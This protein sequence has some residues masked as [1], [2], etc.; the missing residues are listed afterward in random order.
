MRVL[1][2]LS[3][4]VDSAV[5]AYLLQ[6]Q[7]FDVTGAFMK[8]YISENGN[9]STYQ[10]AEEAIK[11]AEFL[12]I[13]LLVFDMQSEYQDRIINYIYDGYSKWITPNPDILCNSL[14]KFDVFLNKAIEQWFDKIAMGHYARIAVDESLK[15]K[16][17][18]L[19]WVDYHKDQSY[20]LAWLNQYQLSKAIFPLWD[21]PKSRVREIAKEIWLPNADRPDS[22]WLCF[23][24]NI[25]IKKFLEQKLPHQKW[26]IVLSDWRV[27]GKHDW[28]WFF[29]VWQRHWLGLNFKAYVIKTDV[30]ENIVVVGDKSHEELSAKS[31]LALDWHWISQDFPVSLQVKTKIRYRQE[32]Q[33][34][35]LISYDKW[36]ME[37]SFDEEQWAIASGQTVVAYLGD[38]C[39]WS[40]IIK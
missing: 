37:I 9:C 19:R 13:E 17:K 30:K 28:A 16:Y 12:W 15:N 20:F 6:K 24:W 1:I 32:P 27:V 14:I 5:A 10:D 26:D 2:W 40:G 21:I 7:G 18:L 29:T 3:W 22:Q 11:V 38:E 8:N 33:A 35:T 23:I 34:A 25:P 36:N 4:W 31:L 39:I